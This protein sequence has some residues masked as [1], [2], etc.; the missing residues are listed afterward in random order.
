MSVAST[1][2]TSHEANY[3]AFA[4]FLG[5]FPDILAVKRFRELQIRNLLFY[6]AEL[7]HLA[8]EL[9]EIEKTDATSMTEASARA[10]FRWKPSM[11]QENTSST[12][13]T[14]NALSSSYAEKML[15]IR[16]TLTSYSEYYHL[17]H[18]I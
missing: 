4:S 13:N 15:L 17:S 3:T 14:T 9:E 8:L 16:R 7:A 2:M 18:L 10:N 11:A 5:S 12:P 6:Q 1:T